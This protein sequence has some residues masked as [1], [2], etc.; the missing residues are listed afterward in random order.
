MIYRLLLLIFSTTL[1]AEPFFYVVIPSYNNEAWCIKNLESVATQNYPDW[2]AVVIND[3]STDK[4]GL[5]LE[6]YVREK[7]L[8]GKVQI[9]H[10]RKRQGMLSNIY[11]AVEKCDP[12]WVVAT[13]D[14]DDWLKDATVLQYLAGIY[15]DKS[16]W[17]T[18]GSW[19][20]DPIGAR[21]CICAEFPPDVIKK[22]QFR[23][24]QYISSQ[25]R[26]F[27]AGLFQKIKKEDFQHKGKFFM[28]AGDVAFMI[29]LLEMSQNGHFY[30]VK[31]PI[32]VYNV[33]NPLNDF[34]A[35]AALQYECYSKIKAKKPYTPLKNRTW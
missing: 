18:Y 10:N 15:Q 29:P 14:G 23:S 16:I 31:E 5:L 4:T 17:M 1:A 30:Y 34:R 13:L 20:S 2:K 19:V 32:Y 35:H 8:S 6:K 33:Q 27:Y 25:L 11:H 28:A 3:C 26:T 24:H 21:P 22:N 9:I 7:N 12:S